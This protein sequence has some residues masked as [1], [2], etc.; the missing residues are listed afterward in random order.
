MGADQFV[1]REA[2]RRRLLGEALPQSRPFG[3]AHLA[4][5]LVDPAAQRVQLAELQSAEVNVHG[6]FLSPKRRAAHGDAANTDQ[7]W[8]RPEKAPAIQW[9]T[10][11]V[12]EQ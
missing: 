4:D 9:A 10:S 6:A 3:I 2:L 8:E 5:A 11:P 12:W 7:V 1:Q